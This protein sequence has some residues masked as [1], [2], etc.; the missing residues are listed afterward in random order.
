MTVRSRGCTDHGGR[1][2]VRPMERSCRSWGE[3]AAAE[4]EM[5]EAGRRL[6]TQFGPGLAFLAT[7]GSDLRPR[8][9]PITIALAAE[10][11]YAFIT[12]GPKLDDLRRGGAY[13]LHAFLPDEVEEEFMI[14]GYAVRGEPRERDAALAA[15]HVASVPDDHVLMRF[16]LD[17]ALHAAYRHRGDWPPTYRR[18]SAAS[19][20]PVEA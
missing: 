7:V 11:L 9:H 2:M 20:S 14:A 18:W 5:A 3:F 4:P 16:V 10:E 19:T 17:R 12:P 13:A 1:A 6:F 15:Y 8:L